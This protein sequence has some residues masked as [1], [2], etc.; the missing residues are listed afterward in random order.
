MSKEYNVVY[1]TIQRDIDELRYFLEK[2]LKMGRTIIVDSH[3]NKAKPIYKVT[4]RG[5]F[6]FGDRDIFALAKILLESRA[7]SKQEITRILD[8]LDSQC[9]DRELFRDTIRNEE[10]HYIPPTHNKD[11]ID[12]LWEINTCVRNK[13]KAKVKYRRQDG[14]I[15]EYVLW[16]LG[17]IF[18]EFYFYLICYVDGKS[19][20]NSIVFR[21]DRFE[22]YQIVEDGNKFP[23]Y[24]R[25][26]F[27]EGE[28]RKRIQFMYTGELMKIQFKFW[29]DS[30]EAVLDRLPTAKVIGYDDENKKAIIE[31]EVYGEG[32][33]RW[34]LSQK[35]FLEVTRPQ[36]YRDEMKKQ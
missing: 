23:L 15:K 10:F 22:E 8:I 12:F 27:E 19:G 20:D 11:L 36:Q 6:K 14:K 30:L 33:K 25:D 32:V 21:V 1:K 28:F 7:F 26:R 3:K 18:S 24:D 4:K 2:D 34:L 5:G 9:E 35:E 31:A 29:G 13:R 17:L 16:P